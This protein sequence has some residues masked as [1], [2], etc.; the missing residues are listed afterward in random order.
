MWKLT[1]VLQERKNSS[2]RNDISIKSAFIDVCEIQMFRKSEILIHLRMT[3]GCR[4][5]IAD[6]YFQWMHSTNKYRNNTN[7][8]IFNRSIV[9]VIGSIQHI[10]FAKLPQFFW[11]REKEGEMEC[12]TQMILGIGPWKN[13]W[14]LSQMKN[15]PL[16]MRKI[17]HRQLNDPTEQ[18]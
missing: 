15:R 11:K 3:S 16:E 8:D 6:A 18:C 1:N 2:N 9:I 7:N 12:W 17:I 14:V 5:S 13:V 10:F 4:F